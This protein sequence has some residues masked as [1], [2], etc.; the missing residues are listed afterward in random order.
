MNPARV[1]L[2]LRGLT[3]IGILVAAG[4]LSWRPSVPAGEIVP[5]GLESP[6][7]AEPPPAIDHAAEQAIVAGNI[8][9]ASRAAAARRFD[10]L[11]TGGG[12]VPE[13]APN[14]ADEGVPRLY[15]TVVG[16]RGASALM[17]FDARVAGAQLY[18]EGDRGGTYRVKKIDEQSV[19]LIGPEG[20]IVLR[21]THPQGST[22]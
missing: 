8:F 3:V 20:R 11:A 9:S 7:V 21:L 18:R 10:P 1:E 19:I 22:R 17:L 2:S 15:G 6:A 16:P 4:A 14:G 5:A 13:S 12:S